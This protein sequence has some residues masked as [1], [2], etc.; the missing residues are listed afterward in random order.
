[1]VGIRGF[2]E[3]TMQD[4]F[5]DFLSGAQASQKEINEALDSRV[6][7]NGFRLGMD[8]QTPH[9]GAGKIVA[10]RQLGGFFVVLV[11]RDSGEITPHFAHDI[12]PTSNTAQSL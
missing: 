4:L 8:V 7:A 3:D 9:D 5:K 11:E 6:E 2:M 12:T 1:M 10:F